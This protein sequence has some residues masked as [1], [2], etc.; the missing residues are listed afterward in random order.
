MKKFTCLLVTLLA[1][2]Y[3]T[4]TCPGVASD[5]TA[6]N[7]FQALLMSS[8][9]YTGASPAGTAFTT[10]TNSI[11]ASSAICGN[12]AQCC[13]STALANFVNVRLA[14]LKT[15]LTT[16]GA[17][18]SKFG[19]YLTK[20]AAVAS[21]TNISTYLTSVSTDLLL[22]DVQAKAFLTQYSTPATYTTDFSAFTGQLVDCFNQYKAAYQKIACQGCSEG[23]TTTLG[24]A[25]IWLG[26]GTTNAAS[27]STVGEITISA[28]SCSTWVNQCIKV[29]TFL[30]R[31]GG[32]VHVAA[33]INKKRDSTKTAVIG[34][35]AT[36]Y[37][38]LATSDAAG[39]TA[40]IT[41]FTNCA[42][43]STVS[44]CTTTTTGDKA[45]LCKAFIKAFD[46]TMPIARL[47]VTNLNAD[48]TSSYPSSRRQLVTISTGKLLIA[49]DGTGVDTT[50]ANTAVIDLPTTGT[51]TFATTDF[52]TWSAGYV[53]PTVATSS[54][55][56]STTKS[57]KVVIGTILSALFAVAF[58]N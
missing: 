18:V 49:A 13:V 44:T 42:A 26:G 4:A 7:S 9:D 3:A 28:T 39:V 16:F 17:A 56:V 47:D 48:P 5:A 30:H 32:A 53:A 52:A 24:G 33:Y 46:T 36:A 23:T 31:V 54:S 37:H 35:F 6:G 11:G 21:N 8:T 57:A 58:L 25:A 19:G 50:S 55:A 15:A 27:T 40:V 34:T 2:Q 41:A 10:S 51:T 12:V 43:D 22:T 14:N 38:S 29:F 1:I 45:T 20:V